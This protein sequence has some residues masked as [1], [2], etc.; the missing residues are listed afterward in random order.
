VKQTAVTV[1]VMAL[2]ASG[3]H[4]E[5]RFMAGSGPVGDISMP[6]RSVLDL[7]YYTV[8][9]QQFDFSCGSAALA[10]L[11]RHHYGY[12]VREDDAFRGMWA[13]GDRAQIRRLGFSLLDMKRYLDG[14]GIA[15]DGYQVSLD[16]VAKTG[17]PGIALIKVRGYSHFVVVKGVSSREVL[18]GDPSTGLHPMPRDAFQ[19]AWNGVY[20]VLNTE[21]PRGRQ[22]FNRN[23]QWAAFSRAPLGDGRL[24]DP[25]SLQA[26]ALT[27]P[28]YRDF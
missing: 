5:P 3:A 6:L 28:F 9:R 7:R 26:L 10:T 13:A 16:Q 21:Q 4:A 17:L 14:R 15:S 8:I 24:F 27:A 22:T 12:R 11:L 23:T 25:V 18:V 20:F 2:A 1:A 19:A